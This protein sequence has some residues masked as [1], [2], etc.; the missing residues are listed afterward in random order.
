[1]ATAEEL[2]IHT[3]KRQQLTD[4]YYSEGIGAGDLNRDGHVDIVYAP[5]ISLRGSMTSTKTAGTTC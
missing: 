3:F 2:A 5:T 1:M 4:V